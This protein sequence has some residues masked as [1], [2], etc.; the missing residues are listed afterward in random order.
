M[1]KDKQ[2]N[3]AN[4]WHVI[5]DHA[6][7]PHAIARGDDYALILETCFLNTE[8]A[9]RI[10]RMLNK[11]EKA[12]KAGSGKKVSWQVDMKKFKGGEKNNG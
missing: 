9:E 2:V 7:I 4:K 8:N 6:C 11:A 12:S 10:A 1:K 3:K 5:R